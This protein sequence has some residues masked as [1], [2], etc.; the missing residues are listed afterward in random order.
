MN[1]LTRRGFALMALAAFALPA[2]ADTTQKVLSIG[3]DVTEI[4]YALGAGD[5]LIARDTTSRFPEAANALPDVGYMRRLS[6]EGVLS[7]DPELI[8]AS[9]GSGPLETIEVLQAADIDYVTLGRG[10]APAEVAA[11]IRK[12]GDALDLS[13]AAETLASTTETALN[14]QLNAA[15]NFD[16]ARKKVM[17]ILSIRDGKITV[18][19]AGTNADAMIKLAGG[20]NA[21]TDFQGYKTLSDE[22]ASTAAPDVILMMNSTGSHGASAAEVFAMPS[23]AITPAAE[24]LN[25]QKI[26][27]IFINGSGPR[28]AG[29]AKQLHDAIYG[30]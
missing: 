20:E 17:F 13:E 9:E 6:P 11:K 25:L 26:D 5:R 3:S 27:G 19:G 12:I 8:L 29:A 23:L 28:T 4:V 30:N 14:D 24:T 22:A 16:G 2:Q 21:L 1:M 7:V 15:E 10:Y 18:S